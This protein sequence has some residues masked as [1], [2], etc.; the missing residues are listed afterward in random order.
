MRKISHDK[1]EREN[2]ERAGRRN[3]KKTEE[4]KV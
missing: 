1:R 2:D 3:T 4:E